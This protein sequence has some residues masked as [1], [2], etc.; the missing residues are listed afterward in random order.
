MS[1][2]NKKHFKGRNLFRNIA[3]CSKMLVSAYPGTEKNQRQETLKRQI[4]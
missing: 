4:I 3:K 1:E 2:Q